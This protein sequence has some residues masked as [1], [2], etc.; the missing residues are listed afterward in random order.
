M[1]L[2][3]RGGGGGGGSGGYRG[4]GALRGVL[5]CERKGRDDGDDDST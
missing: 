3:A 5:R 2:A 4:L 1:G